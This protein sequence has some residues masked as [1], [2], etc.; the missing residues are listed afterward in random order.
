MDEYFAVLPISQSSSR[1]ESLM[2]GV[3]GNKGFV[4]NHRRILEPGIQ[5]ADHP[6]VL[7]LA[8]RQAAMFRLGE[9]G[10]RPL[11]LSHI[12]DRWAR[13]FLSWFWLRH[14]RPDPDVALDSRVRSTR[15]QRVQRFD[16][17]R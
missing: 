2:A 7:R 1:F 8:Q 10:V 16:G 6:L 17:E 5:I 11:Q 3:W 4:E 14:L 15:A 12:R 9:I 13:R